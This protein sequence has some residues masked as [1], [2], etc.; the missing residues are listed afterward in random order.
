M[1]WRD[2]EAG[3]AYDRPPVTDGNPARGA[4]LFVPFSLEP[5]ASRTIRL[6]L[7]WYVPNPHLRAATDQ[8]ELYRPWYAGRFGNIAALI[9]YWRTY[10][11]ELRER[12]ARFTECFYDTTLPSEAVEAIAANLCIL[13]SP[14]VMRQTDGRFWGWEGCDGKEG[15]GY[16]TCTHVWNYA[17]AVAHLF[18]EL[19]RSLRETEFTYTQDERG[20]QNFRVPLPIQPAVHDFYAAL[21]GQ[22]GG[23]VKTHREWRISGDIAWLRRWWPRVRA[24]LDYCIETWDPRRAGWPEEP[25]HN[26]YDIEFWGP[27]GFASSFYLAALQAAVSMGA[28]LN[29]DVEPYRVLL[30]K[31]GIYANE[32]LFNGEYFFQQVKW[33][34]MRAVDVTAMGYGGKYSPEALALLHNEGPKYQYG[35]GCLSDG[36]LGAWLALSC[37]AG[38]VL[39][40]LKVTSH[41]R[42][43]HHHNLKR[44]LSTHVNPQRPTFANGKDGGLLLCSWP[45]GGKPSVPFVYS[46]EVWTGIEYQART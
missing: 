34:G 26:T 12:T 37:G 11:N 29:E 32:V 6:Q 2:V 18:P 27:N 10:Y 42:A 41:L 17:Q 1:A 30:K 36:V 40:P 7:A 14:T 44:D 43:I 19:E 20:H 4:T 33:K 46:D 5:G 21:D 31:G 25:H 15:L 35:A 23:I 13:K 9:E 45:H 24:S 8:R 28:A 3:A 22:L 16:G 38:Q 39:D